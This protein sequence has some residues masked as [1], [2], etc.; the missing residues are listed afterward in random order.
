MRLVWET[1]TQD[2]HN[3]S[4]LEACFNKLQATR[5]EYGPLEETCNELEELDWEEYEVK[6]LEEHVLKHEQSRTG[7]RDSNLNSHLSNLEAGDSETPE[8]IKEEPHPL[9]I[10]RD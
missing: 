5:D 4:A 9:Y 2:S 3:N 8:T 10:R 7:S 6:E 1:W